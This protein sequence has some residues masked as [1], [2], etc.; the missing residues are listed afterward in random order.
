M[1]NQLASLWLPILLAALGVWFWAFLSWAMLSLH[2]GDS[3]GLPDEDATMNALR[4]L[5]IPPGVYGFPH[6]GTHSQA[7]DPKF[8]EK[9]K[10]GPAGMLY[11]WRDVNM[12][13]NMLKSFLVCVVV[14]ILVAYLGLAAGLTKS[15]GFAHLFQVLGTAGVLSHSFAFLPGMIWFQ[16]TTS[17][18]VMG[19]VDG[20]ISGLIIGAIMSALWVG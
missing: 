5:K 2:R 16:A 9:W 12:G 1:I 11:V 17:A 7:K 15:W 6:C 19:V 8:I 13:A 4:S 14:N 3:K 20:I 18:K 10:T